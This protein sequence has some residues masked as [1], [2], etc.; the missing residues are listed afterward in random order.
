[1]PAFL[2][3][4]IR[5]RM[6]DGAKTFIENHDGRLITYAGLDAGS[7]Q[8]ANVL[9]GLGVA[10]GDRV[11]VQLAQSHEAIRLHLACLRAGAVVLPLPAASTANQLAYF[12]RSAAPTGFPFDPRFQA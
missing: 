12:L 5:R 3:D 11:A 2:Y 8:L 4:I 1:M 9:V 10:P 7:A 6:P